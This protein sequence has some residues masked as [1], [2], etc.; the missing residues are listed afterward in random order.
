MK[1]KLKPLR[2]KY[3]GTVI[4]VDFDDG[5]GDS[6]ELWDC[7]DFQPS[8][9]ELAEAEITR[10]QYNNNEVVD[11]DSLF[12]DIPARDALEVCDGHFESQKTYERALK[13]IAAINSY[14]E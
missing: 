12:G 7:A 1:A 8:D 3:Y 6:I 4:D 2:G 10:E 11:H 13:L 14:E 9:R 5:G